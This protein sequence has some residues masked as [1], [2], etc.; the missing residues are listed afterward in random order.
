MA[1]SL[2][3][4]RRRTAFSIRAFSTEFSALWSIVRTSAFPP[5]HIT[6]RTS[7]MFPARP[8]NGHWAQNHQQRNM[9]N[10]AALVK[11]HLETAAPIHK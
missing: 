2:K 8:E 7:P 10:I 4:V 6:A 3:H 5:L 9:Y 1:L 11:R